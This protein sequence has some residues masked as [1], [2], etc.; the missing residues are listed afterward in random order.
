MGNTICDRLFLNLAEG[1]GITGKWSNEDQESVGTCANLNNT[2]RSKKLSGLDKSI[3][4][5]MKRFYEA[6][7]SQRSIN[8]DLNAATEMNKLLP[9]INSEAAHRWSLEDSET[10]LN[11]LR[12]LIKDASNTSTIVNEIN[13]LTHLYLLYQNYLDRKRAELDKSKAAL[14]KETL[15]ASH[16]ERTKN[17]NP[18]KDGFIN[19]LIAV[20]LKS[21][22]QR[23]ENLK[24]TVS[25][26]EFVEFALRV[27]QITSVFTP[28]D[29]TDPEDFKLN[30]DIYTFVDNVIDLLEV[31][32]TSLNGKQL[33]QHV[34]G[35]IKVSFY[36]GN[37]SLHFKLASMML[38]TGLHKSV[39]TSGFEGCKEL[40]KFQYFT[41]YE[42]HKSQFKLTMSEELNRE[43]PMWACFDHKKMLISTPQ[44]FALYSSNPIYGEY[45]SGYVGS[46]ESHC[47]YYLDG[48][49][50]VSLAGSTNHTTMNFIEV[51]NYS[52]EFDPVNLLAADHPLKAAVSPKFKLAKPWCTAIDPSILVFLSK[53][54]SEED[55]TKCYYLILASSV[56]KF[57]R[58]AAVQWVTPVVNEDG[59]LFDQQLS[60]KDLRGQLYSYGGLLVF[61]SPVARTL[62]HPKT[63][64]LLQT[65]KTADAFSGIDS[66]K[67][68]I[69]RI[70]NDNSVIFYPIDCFNKYEYQTTWS[71]LEMKVDRNG[72]NKVKAAGF[73][74]D[75][76]ESFEEENPDKPPKPAQPA[77]PEEVPEVDTEE[78][79]ANKDSFLQYVKTVLKLVFTSKI[80]ALNLDL[81]SIEN[82]EKAT[83][84]FQP[85]SIDVRVVTFEALAGM[86]GSLEKLKESD[87]KSTLLLA[88]FKLLDVHLNIASRVQSSEN[89]NEPKTLTSKLVYTLR[90]LVS[91]LRLPASAV[92][93]NVG[94]FDKLKVNIVTNLISLTQKLTQPLSSVRTVVESMLSQHCVLAKKEMFRL[95]SEILKLRKKGM[96]DFEAVLNQAVEVVEEKVQEVVTNELIIFEG[97]MANHETT[98]H[99]NQNLITNVINFYISLIAARTTIPDHLLQRLVNFA[100]N[101]LS[102][103][104]ESLCESLKACADKLA[105]EDSLFDVETIF[106]NSFSGF[107]LFKA[108]SFMSYA[109]LWPELTETLDSYC[110][111]FTVSTKSI[112]F[113]KPA[114]E[115]PEKPD[116]D[117]VID[118]SFNINPATR[119]APMTQ[120]ACL[121]LYT[122]LKISVD[123]LDSELFRVYVFTA[124]D[125][126]SHNQG[127]SGNLTETIFL[128]NQRVIPGVPLEID[129]NWVKVVIVSENPPVYWSSRDHTVKIRVLGRDIALKKS[130]KLETLIRICSNFVTLNLLK[131]IKTLGESDKTLSSLSEQAVISLE[132]VLES[133]LFENG[134]SRVEFDKIYK[135]FESAGA[136]E[137][138]N[139]REA[140]CEKYFDHILALLNITG[141]LAI[142]FNTLCTKLQSDSVKKT[143]YANIGGKIGFVLVK[144]VYLLA[145]SHSSKLD[146]VL[147]GLG[148][149]AEFE[150]DADLKKLWLIVTKIRATSRTYETDR[151]YQE[152]FK[153]IF[154]LFA[155]EP[156]ARWMQQQEKAALPKDDGE[157]NE[158]VVK[159]KMYIEELRTNGRNPS[160]GQDQ[161]LAEMIIRFLGLQIQSDQII[162]I[163]SQRGKQF[164]V[165]GK[166]IDIVLQYV[167]QNIENIHEALLMFNQIF[168]QNAHQAGYLMVDHAGLSSELVDQRIAALRQLF[169]AILEF[170]YKERPQDSDCTNEILLAVESLKWLW[171]GKEI[172]CIQLIDINRIWSS[173]FTRLGTNEKFRL[174]MIDLCHILLKFCA[175]K[176]QD[177]QEDQEEVL[178]LKR[179][180][181]LIDENSISS[182][183]NQNFNFL[184]DV[185]NT[186][187]EQFEKVPVAL[188]E[189]DYEF[190]TIYSADELKEK[191]TLDWILKN[192]DNSESY[193]QFNDLD[194]SYL[195]YDVPL[196]E[197]LLYKRLPPI[198]AFEE[199]GYQNGRRIKLTENLAALGQL[200]NLKVRSWIDESSKVLSIF[201]YY[202]YSA[203]A[204]AKLFF[205]HRDNLK[206]VVKIAFGRFPQQLSIVA[207]KVLE[208]LSEHVNHMVLM[209]DAPP[210]EKVVEGLLPKYQALFSGEQ[211]ALSTNDLISSKISFLRRLLMNEDHCDFVIE[212]LRKLLVKQ[213]SAETLLV[214]DLLDYSQLDLMPGLVVYDK[215]DPTREQLLLLDSSPS[216]FSKAYIRDVL[217]YRY[218]IST[219]MDVSKDRLDRNNLLRGQHLAVCLRTKNYCFLPKSQIGLF[220]PVTNKDMLAFIVDDLELVSIVARTQLNATGMLARFHL[221]QILKQTH[222]AKYRA[223]MEQIHKSVGELA[224]LNGYTE[225]ECTAGIRE[226]FASVSASQTDSLEP[227]KFD[228]DSKPTAISRYIEMKQRLLLSLRKQ[229]QKDKCSTSD[230]YWTRQFGTDA[231][232]KKDNKVNFNIF[233]F[234][235]TLKLNTDF[236]AVQPLFD[237]GP[238]TSRI[239]QVAKEG[240]HQTYLN[241]LYS[242]QNP[243]DLETLLFGFMQ[244]LSVLQFKHHMLAEVGS[245]NTKIEVLLA[246]QKDKNKIIDVVDR[247]F[248]R[249][250]SK[251][252]VYWLQKIADRGVR[253]VKNPELGKQYLYYMYDLVVTLALSAEDLRSN[254]VL[255]NCL[256]DSI[257]TTVALLQAMPK[258]SLD[259]DAHRINRFDQLLSI[260]LFPKIVDSYSFKRTHKLEY[261]NSILIHFVS[262]VAMHALVDSAALK[263]AACWSRVVRH[264][265]KLRTA[266][267]KPAEMGNELIKGIMLTNLADNAEHRKKFTYSFKDR[268]FV[269]LDSSYGSFFVTEGRDS[270]S[271]YAFGLA[272]DPRCEHM[273][274]S[275]EMYDHVDR[276]LNILWKF[277]I[278]VRKKH[279]ITSNMQ[280]SYCIRDCNLQTYY[281]QLTYKEDMSSRIDFVS[282]ECIL[283][284]GILYTT[285]NTSRPY[286]L[287]EGVACATSNSS[288][289]VAYVKAQTKELVV[290]FSES[291]SRKPDLQGAFFQM[292]LSRNSEVYF[293][294]D[295]SAHARIVKLRYFKNRELLCLDEKGGLLVI[296]S[297]DALHSTL[298]R[299]VFGQAFTAAFEESSKCYVQ[300][301]YLH[302]EWRLVDFNVCSESKILFVF[303]HGNDLVCYLRTEDDSLNRIYRL[304]APGRLKKSACLRAHP[305]TLLL[306]EDGRAWV[307]NTDDKSI[308]GLEVIGEEKRYGWVDKATKIIDFLPGESACLTIEQLPDG[309]VEF[310][311]LSDRDGKDHDSLNDMQEYTPNPNTRFSHLL[312]DNISRMAATA[313]DT[314]L[315]NNLTETSLTKKDKLKRRQTQTYPLCYYHTNA[316]PDDEAGRENGFTYA[317]ADRFFS[318]EPKHVLAEP[319]MLQ[320]SIL[321][322]FS[323]PL[324]H[325]DSS[326]FISNLAQAVQDYNESEAYEDISE[327]DTWPYL[328]CTYNLVFEKSR[329]VRPLL[330]EG[331]TI[332]AIRLIGRQK[333]ELA[334]ITS[335]LSHCKFYSED[336]AKSICI[337]P[338]FIDMDDETFERFKAENESLWLEDFQAQKDS[339]VAR[340]ETIMRIFDK[341][342]D[343]ESYDRSFLEAVF[344]LSRS[345]S[346]LQEYQTYSRGTNVPYVDD[347]L[348]FIYAGMKI[349]NLGYY[350]YCTVLPT[351]QYAD[352]N[353]SHRELCAH[354]AFI[355]IAANNCRRTDYENYFSLTVNRMRGMKHTSLKRQNFSLLTQF[356]YEVDQE[357][358]SF[359]KGR[360]LLEGI[361]IN[362]MGEAGTDAG[363]PRRE[364]L[365]NLCKELTEKLKLFI[366][367][368]NSLHNVGEEREKMV[369]NP[370]ANSQSDL[371]NYYKVGMLFAVSIKLRECLE[372]DLPQILWKYIMSRSSSPSPNPHLGRHQ[373]HQHQPVRLHRKD[374]VHERR[375]PRVPRGNLR[376]F[377]LGRPGVRAR[378]PRQ[379]QEARSAQQA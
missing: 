322:Y 171:R 127:R 26:A 217:H 27:A 262:N 365:T 52:Y 261:L 176:A 329:E 34:A 208:S 96:K 253:A 313:M 368:P 244:R 157:L 230:S 51:R 78:A 38:R 342:L 42:H 121:P 242:L 225:Q 209:Q 143:Q 158:G 17:L 124:Q 203:P 263:Q 70:Q 72:E 245:L 188:N 297:E 254:N 79:K 77:E 4:P 167:N 341:K 295:L 76:D 35:L 181:S 354:N 331:D 319:H 310:G 249:P 308:E 378:A 128:P 236:I 306:F 186:D 134:F 190:L 250:F 14:L 196:P 379:A 286:V 15:D 105:R 333:K 200:N 210:L 327:A 75:E 318:L 199:V 323:R 321:L 307:V 59:T 170:I 211:E 300:S 64:T 99:A 46:Y 304:E 256:V 162:E 145:L 49:I 246:S 135:L 68:R 92:S 324:F 356:A 371:D 278:D 265:A 325:N 65:T 177:M 303:S 372:L 202:V 289:W 337:V 89:K 102:V 30:Q 179:Q 257:E 144:S 138:E 343:D 95:L 364:Y 204:M 148:N 216:L 281:M 232:S 259:I 351:F 28:A 355:N 172:D 104:M 63:G 224:E 192:K 5:E 41:V 358:Q 291:I 198:N 32:N 82:H 374:G 347:E 370:K 18:L 296:R 207:L 87:F 377:P 270:T 299:A 334:Q 125:F 73:I 150:L 280:D 194:P 234:K 189:L 69:C 285:M 206:P 267:K 182:I 213:R 191:Y 71:N 137:D 330:P 219:N 215:Q 223:P 247:I 353:L 269:E 19:S 315:F 24:K 115:N 357:A 235:P 363:G 100:A 231:L 159:M 136:G 113:P 23:A 336:C 282:N 161:S 328:Y 222:S 1:T 311:T 108:V 275:F 362:F 62:I 122:R 83:V 39:A 326:E 205:A 344:G 214:L 93:E 31:Y 58:P 97:G 352:L 86:L 2:A 305:E 180:V 320:T 166:A 241:Y 9:L 348:N 21:L 56:N 141:D 43:Q 146:G 178:T 332:M 48:N 163:I 132:S 201:Y 272:T 273:V 123:E 153:K 227:L 359:L 110:K 81:I 20:S 366:K 160:K 55:P 129:T 173:C 16:K 29:R 221:S 220:D 118:I 114:S 40:E 185:L 233:P 301:Y 36:L 116:E 169:Q 360:G 290:I 264:V 147:F 61:L 238:V 226:L 294:L 283:T 142:S 98:T 346:D 149:M 237:Q 131:E 240:I 175:R 111:Q 11:Q 255:L 84:L 130:S 183:L 248:R 152:L 103:S 361:E 309:S 279:Y 239:V 54:V 106:L 314:L 184:I 44:K 243:D 251:D 33:A 218:D 155:I 94:V 47:Y 367:S 340:R 335:L 109:P 126:D 156:S 164:E 298:F 302:P 228:T 50:W 268:P 140:L 375:R 276:D 168:R 373:D 174:S 25:K 101:S 260:I 53:Y 80:G 349:V 187:L 229:A 271:S 284:E 60:E 90:K 10:Q 252:E 287:D 193:P 376:H 339:L 197:S 369:P 112:V 258:S 6:A 119:R 120:T 139:P 277:D 154:M 45:L 13:Y 292:N 338:N 7:Q 293:V 88:V 350:E 165:F 74:V 274:R 107:F 37:V 151:Q 22:N 212:A 316:E 288:N 312:A 3:A 117:S 91:S 8:Y 66:V 57:G 85:N 195:G 12:F 345:L 266:A 133:H 317:P 67:D